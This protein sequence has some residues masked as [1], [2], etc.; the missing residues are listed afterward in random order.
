MINITHIKRNKHLLITILLFSVGAL[1]VPFI[2]LPS[3]GYHWQV[4]ANVY[5]PMTMQNNYSDGAPGSFFTVNGYNFAP[6]DKLDVTA[7]GML[8]GEVSTDE[9]GAFTFMINSAQ[10][11][12]G[13]YYIATDADN[14]PRSLFYLA[15]AAPLRAQEGQGPIFTLPSGAAL[16][17]LHLPFMTR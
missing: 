15:A 6:D 12:E 9:L 10:A 1:L 11:A 7:N 8:L 5:V 4:Y 3:E 2:G 16:Q 17:V 13:A 14:S